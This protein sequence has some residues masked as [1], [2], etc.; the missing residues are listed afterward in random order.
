MRFCDELKTE[1][2]L[3]KARNVA[4]NYHTVQCGDTFTTE[5]LSWLLKSLTPKCFSRRFLCLTPL[6]LFWDNV[7][8]SVEPCL[9]GR[10]CIIGLRIPVLKLS[11]PLVRPSLLQFQ[12]LFLLSRYRNQVS[13]VLNLLQFYSFISRLRFITIFLR[14]NNW[15]VISCKK[16]ST[17]LKVQMYKRVILNKI[18]VSHGNGY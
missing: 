3:T 12:N 15:I 16:Y 11:R 7:C 4:R 10:R 18:W 1:S 8:G 9:A 6:L 2:K 13:S 5:M 14:S 17:D